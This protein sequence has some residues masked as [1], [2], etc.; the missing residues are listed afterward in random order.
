MTDKIEQITQKIYNEGVIKAKEDADQ[1]VAEAK[2]KA[3]D[4]VHS[5]LKEKEKIIGEAQKQADELI[6][7]TETELQLAA[8]QFTSKL[9]QQITAIVTTSQVGES[10][11]EAF[12]DIGFMKEMIMTIIENWNPQK[13]GEPALQLLLPEKDKEKLT[14]FFDS[15]VNEILDRGVEIKFDPKTK[16][17]FKIGPADGSYVISFTDKDFENYFIGYFKDRTK[18]LLFEPVD[19]KK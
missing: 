10:V 18:K 3:E 13:H 7:K 1:I 15:K 11:K 14:R 16:N 2:K 5:A 12:D 6:S 4:I 9:K 17:G 8:R 19:Q